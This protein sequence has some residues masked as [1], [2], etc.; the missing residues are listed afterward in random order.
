MKKEQ[1]FKIGAI[2]ALATLLNS[3]NSEPPY[4]VINKEVSVSV[5][6]VTIDVNTGKDTNRFF[7]C[8]PRVLRD[9]LE[10]P[11]NASVVDKLV[12]YKNL[13]KAC[14]DYEEPAWIGY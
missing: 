12:K 5:E 3:C 4:G 11:K 6:N 8:N 1:L 9:E 2:T 13:E 14:P 10:L 7:K